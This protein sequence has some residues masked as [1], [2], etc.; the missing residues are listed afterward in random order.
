MVDITTISI[1]TLE[2]D[3]RESENDISACQLALDN[4]IDKYSGGLVRE[5]LESN[6]HFVE[7]ITKE[8]NRRAGIAEAGQNG[9]T[10]TV[11]Q[12]AADT[13]ESGL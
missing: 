1:G 6:R 10:T 11:C 7:V 2:K 8:L 13:K 4:G 5:R 9:L 12:N 3:L